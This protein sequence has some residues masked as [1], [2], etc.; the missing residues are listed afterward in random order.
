MREITEFDTA[1]TTTKHNRN[2]LFAWEKDQQNHKNNTKKNC[3][4]MLVR[5]RLH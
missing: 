4:D 5:A 2:M 1:H 3:F